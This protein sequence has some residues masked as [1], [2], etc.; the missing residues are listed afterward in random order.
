MK[1]LDISFQVSEMYFETLRGKEGCDLFQCTLHFQAVLYPMYP[2]MVIR[3]S[4][5]TYSEQ[6]RSLK[7]VEYVSL[8]VCTQCTAAQCSNNMD[9]VHLS[10]P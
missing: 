8:T 9:L 4:H 5:K 3:R 10:L 6:Y 2:F 7:T 1:P